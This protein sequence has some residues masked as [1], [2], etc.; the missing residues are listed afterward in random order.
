[1]LPLPLLDF[2]SFWTCLAFWLE[3]S[4]S[5]KHGLYSSVQKI[6]LI[7]MKICIFS[8]G[9]QFHEF[10]VFWTH[11]LI[12]LYIALGVNN[13][14]WISFKINFLIFKLNISIYQN[15]KIFCLQAEFFQVFKS[16]SAPEQNNAGI[17]MQRIF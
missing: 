15:I 10:C 17:V 7:I 12:S 2:F 9:T 1:M 13:S 11:P 8:N 6:I 5:P 4:K 3:V 16:N 14:K